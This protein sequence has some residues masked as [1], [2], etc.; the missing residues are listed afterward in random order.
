LRL[1]F[2]LTLL[3]LTTAAG[4]ADTRYRGRFYFGPDVQVFEPCAQLKAYWVEGDAKTLKPLITRSEALR[5][6][7]GKDHLPVYV[8][9]TG[10][11]DTGAAR[12]GPAED[13]D[14][15]LRV[16]RVLRV[17]TS[18]PKRCAE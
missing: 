2:A 7:R 10:R 5:N 1:A 13:Y 8:E 14:G 11:I 17:S 15:Y 3:V 12:E 9:L 6:Q 4:A 18:I 16:R